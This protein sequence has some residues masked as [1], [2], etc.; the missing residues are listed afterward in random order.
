MKQNRNAYRFFLIASFIAINALILFGIGSVL[1]FLNTGADKSSM[2][3]LEREA[4]EVYL[5]KV[6]WTDTVGDGRE[7]SKQVLGEIERDY[8]RAWY[9]RNIAY[10]ENNVFGL[11]NHYTDS[12]LIKFKKIIDINKEKDITINTTTITHF[13]DL[14]FYSADGQ[15]VVFRD[16]N[17]QRHQQIVVKDSLLIQTRD[18]ENYRVVK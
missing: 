5:P 3:H 1:S 15:L 13:P 16:N 18:T 17:I 7:I 9:V 2:L 11:N 8:K 10:R 14:E 6:I 12:S 4:Y